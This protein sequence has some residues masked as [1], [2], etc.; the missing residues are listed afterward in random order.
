MSKFKTRYINYSDRGF[1][2]KFE[3]LIFDENKS[4]NKI[5]TTVTKILNEILENGDNGLNDCVSKFDKIKFI[6]FI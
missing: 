5:K 1:K 3:N 2:K 4:N 6:F